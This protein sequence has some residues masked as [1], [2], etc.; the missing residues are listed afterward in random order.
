M[1]YEYISNDLLIFLQK[2][3]KKGGSNMQN[4]NNKKEGI[5][6]FEHKHFKVF[7]IRTCKFLPRL[8]CSYF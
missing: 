4:V 5:E 8:G 7:F 2:P 6:T 1:L 3:A